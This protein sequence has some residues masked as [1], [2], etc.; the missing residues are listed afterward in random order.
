[1]DE[2]CG[3]EDKGE[4]LR[5]TSAYGDVVIVRDHCTDDPMVRC[6]YQ[7]PRA[8]YVN[9]VE[10]QWDHENAER[11]IRQAIDEALKAH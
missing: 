3:M 9:G 8:F 4:V 5:V 6:R 10:A 11:G 2:F 1:L 7:I